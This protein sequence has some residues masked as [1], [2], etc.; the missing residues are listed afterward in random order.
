MWK[1]LLRKY[2]ITVSYS[3]TIVYGYTVLENVVVSDDGILINIAE[4]A[5][6]IVV[7]K[8]CFWMDVC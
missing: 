3:C 7:T 2:L 1:C 6:D 8:L 5:N 4:R